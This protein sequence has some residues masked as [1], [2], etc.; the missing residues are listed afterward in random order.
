MV[1]WD[2]IQKLEGKGVKQGYVPDPDNSQSGVTIA[3]GVDLGQQT[4]DG[5]A[6]Y[7]IPHELVTKL[8]PYIGLKKHAAVQFLRAN[9]LVLTAAEVKDLDRIIHNEHYNA[10]VREYDKASS[11]PFR[12]IP[13]AAQTVICSVAFQYGTQL[14]RRTPNFWRIVTSQDWP[15]AIRALR[16]F[17][18]RYPT[19]RNK[20][21]D[22]LEKHLKDEPVSV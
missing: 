6:S 17:N 5:L 3:S 9:P 13:D 12:K 11:I 1:N 15:R 8:A 20:E 21:A 22:Y 4:L 2:F 7:S 18:D 10:L 16:N 19:R 14:Y